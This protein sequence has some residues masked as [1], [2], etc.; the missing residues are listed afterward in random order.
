M[1]EL[2]EYALGKDKDEFL[3]DLV[4]WGFIPGRFMYEYLFPAPLDTKTHPPVRIS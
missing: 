1:S 2:Y 3:V 4:H